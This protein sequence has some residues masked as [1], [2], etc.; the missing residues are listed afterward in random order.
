MKAFVI[1]ENEQAARE[2]CAGARTMADEVV[3]VRVG[4]DP[5]VNVAD[6]CV[7]VAVPE[8]NV[9]DDAYVTVNS[10]FDAEQAEVVLAEPTRRVK[11]LAGRLASHLGTSV[12]TDAMEI[13]EGVATT[14]FFGGVGQRKS[15]HSGSV[16]LYTVGSGVFDGAAA[17]GTDVVEEAEFQAPENAIVR[18]GA[19]DL[20]VSDV[21]L[22]AADVVIGCGRGF[23]AEEDLQA[24]RDLAAKVGGEL[25]CSRPLAEGVDWFPREAYIGVSGVIVAPKVY[26]C[27]G[28]SGQMQHMVGVNRS[29]TVVAINK[30]KNAPVFKQCD[31]GIVGDVKT[32]LPALTAAL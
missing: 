2:L 32:V 15:K 19:A 12:I 9:V 22:A 11:S 17:T 26:F 13:A 21:N 29:Q 20:P 30:D 16:A 14:M 10:V 25:G 28:I 24:A 31:Y 6:K 3:L 7:H 27:C 8:G 5:V 4:G 23:A 18:R 1:A